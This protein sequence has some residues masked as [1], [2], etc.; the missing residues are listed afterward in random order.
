[1]N[2][3]LLQLLISVTGIA[4]MVGLCW[5]LFGRD[6]AAIES[7]NA[8]A[9]TMA[10]DVPGFC[11]G[12]TA[13]SAD[14]RGA[15]IENACDGAVFLAVMRGDGL[16]TRRIAGGFSLRRN[17]SRLEFHLPDFTLSHASLDLADAAHWEAR[18][19]GLAA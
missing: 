17:G 16:V 6:M 11:A 13:L 3:Q 19:K 9:E 4:V 12:A 8:L 7:A 18:L 15:L 2:P 1:M 5:A 14:R 10:R